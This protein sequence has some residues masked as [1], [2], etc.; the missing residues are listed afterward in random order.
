MATTSVTTNSSYITRS[1]NVPAFSAFTVYIQG[2]VA[3]DEASVFAI[4]VDASQYL[5]IYASGGK[6]GYEQLDGF[7][8]ADLFTHGGAWWELAI[9]T[10]GSNFQPYSRIAG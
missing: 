10:S 2:H 4:K 6:I 3:T 8:S 7:S 9:T 5:L 1:T